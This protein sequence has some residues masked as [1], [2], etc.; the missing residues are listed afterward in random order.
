VQ[1]DVR[2]RREQQHDHADEQNLPGPG[3]LRLEVEAIVT[4]YL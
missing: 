2:K 3:R 4:K 1:K